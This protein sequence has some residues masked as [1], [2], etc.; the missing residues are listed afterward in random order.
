MYAK[1][2]PLRLGS[3]TYAPLPCDD[4]YNGGTVMNLG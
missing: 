4:S 1:E 3:F 2:T